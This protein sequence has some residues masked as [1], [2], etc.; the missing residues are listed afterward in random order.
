MMNSVRH[1]E[2]E[3]KAAGFIPAAFKI[4]AGNF[5]NP[6]RIPGFRILVCAEIFFG[7]ITTQSIS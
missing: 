6:E 2:S 1:F 3:L 4:Y 5:K 7:Y